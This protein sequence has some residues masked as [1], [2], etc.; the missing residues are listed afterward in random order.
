MSSHALLVANDFLL[1]YSCVATP[2][3]LLCFDIYRHRYALLLLCFCFASFYISNCCNAA[4]L[5]YIHVYSFF[6][7]TVLLLLLL[8]VCV[9]VR[10]CIIYKYMLAMLYSYFTPT[11][12]RIYII[13]ISFIYIGVWRVVGLLVERQPAPTSELCQ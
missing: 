12:L 3:L 7:P 5:K 1:L 13:Y 10:V 11:L 6:T 4:L 2:L 8:C 9:C